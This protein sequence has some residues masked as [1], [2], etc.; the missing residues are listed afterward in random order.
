[1][2]LSASEL[3]LLENHRFLN[4]TLQ[5]VTDAFL[6]GYHVCMHW[7]DYQQLNNSHYSV[8]EGGY[9][10]VIKPRQKS[11]GEAE[12]QMI[13]LSDKALEILARYGSL[14]DLPRFANSVVNRYIKIVAEQVG[15]KTHLTWKVGRKTHIHVAR[16]KKM[17]RE[18]SICKLA[19]W[20]ST[21][22]LRAYA[23][24]EQETLLREFFV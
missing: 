10:W 8:D 13:P 1:M 22:Q 23:D 6:F 4:P 2:V 24:L 14:E 3:E 20:T 9:H 5:R 17:M 19:G 18:T 21:R 11:I 15:I 7:S 16:N 12:W